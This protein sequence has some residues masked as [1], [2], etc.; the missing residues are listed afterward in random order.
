[1]DRPENGRIE[2]FKFLYFL[3]HLI[4]V[5]LTVL[6]LKWFG[7][8]P[9]G[10]NWH[11]VTMSIG[12]VFLYGNCELKVQLFEKK[13]KLISSTAILIY[14]GFR[15]G[16]KITLKQM[17]A[18]IHALALIFTVYGLIVAFK[19]HSSPHLYSLHSWIGMGAVILFAFQYVAGLLCFLFPVVR[20]SFKVSYMP[21]HIFFGI[22]GFIL[23]MIA[24][25]LGICEKSF[26]GSDYKLLSANT[27][28]VNSIGSLLTIYGSL[29][30]YLVT[31]P[32]YKRQPLPEEVP[33]TN[34]NCEIL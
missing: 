30:I 3:Q 5:V 9:K 23:A 12:M 16:S 27:L 31:D 32:N 1:M 28:F 18:R 22:L 29:V 17:H 19:S 10:F 4:S 11:P 14:R 6:F 25:L 20:G 7:I 26:N 2:K 15:F 24:C 21:L 33:I 13:S 8:P 34:P